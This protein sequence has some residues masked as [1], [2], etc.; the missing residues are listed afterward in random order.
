MLGYRNRASDEATALMEAD[1]K[2]QKSPVWQRHY[3]TKGQDTYV[4]SKKWLNFE[5]KRRQRKII[6]Y[7]D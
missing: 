4:S 7:G 1:R 6:Q 2:L 5:A 3:T